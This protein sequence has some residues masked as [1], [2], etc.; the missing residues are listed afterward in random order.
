M[1]RYT[2]ACPNCDKPF[3]IEEW[4]G[5]QCP[6]C[7]EKYCWDELFDDGTSLLCFYRLK[8]HFPGESREQWEAR[9][10]KVRNINAELY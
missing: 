2:I 8:E 6:H 10:E 1:S 4:V 5:G 9:Q 3:D 7:G